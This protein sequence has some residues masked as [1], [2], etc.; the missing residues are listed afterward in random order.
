MTSVNSSANPVGYMSELTALLIEHEENQSQSAH[1][2]RE[3]ARTRFLQDTQAQVKQ[4]NQAADATLNAALVSGVI[5]VAGG[6]A[7]VVGAVDQFKAD[8]NSAGLDPKDFCGEVIEMR[9]T[10]A[11]ETVAAKVWNTVGKTAAAFD[12][13]TMMLGESAAEHHRAAAKEAEAAE[14]RDQWQ[15]SDA[16]TSIDKAN[17]Q[18]D[19]LLDIY[20]G[21]QHDQAAAN[22]SLVGRI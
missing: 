8:T 10:V 11:S 7:D 1:L 4:L 13:P 15:A 16:S 2:E 5:S 12:K 20:Q 19:A 18:S 17:K 14:A 6:V 3:A 22:N 21:T 9:K